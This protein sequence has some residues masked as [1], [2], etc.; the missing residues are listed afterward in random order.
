MG[1]LKFQKNYMD[2][3][4]EQKEVSEKNIENLE[5]WLKNQ[6]KTENKNFGQGIFGQGIFCQGI[7]G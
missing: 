1:R 4:D 3:F 2:N 6:T 5:I 7:F